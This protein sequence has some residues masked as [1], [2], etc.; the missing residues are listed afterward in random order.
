MYA[1]II[2]HIIAYYGKPRQW[3]PSPGRRTVVQISQDVSTGPL[4]CP[5]TRSLAPL[6][7]LLAP[8]CSLRSLSYSAALICTLTRSLCSLPSSWESENFDV[9]KSGCFEPQWFNSWFFF[10]SLAFMGDLTHFVMTSFGNKKRR[11][12]LD[13]LYRKLSKLSFK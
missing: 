8:P 13:F 4:V 5:F 9:S 2:S 7:H 10:G 1:S 3:T 6:T 12:K 11:K